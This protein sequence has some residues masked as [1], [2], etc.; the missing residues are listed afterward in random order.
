[1]HGTCCCWQGLLPVALG[2]PSLCC[3]VQE[4]CMLLQC[5]RWPL[6]PS[7]RSLALLHC[8]PYHALL[9]YPPPQVLEEI[10][11]QHIPVMTAWNKVD[12]CP[13]P[14]LVRALAADQPDTHVISGRSGEGLPELLAAIGGK[15]QESMVQVGGAGLEAWLCSRL[16]W[17]PAVSARRQ[18][19]VLPVGHWMPHHAS[20]VPGSH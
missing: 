12:A 20:P 13:D 7:I 3:K 2:A 5:F 8:W 9:H 17:L 19:L 18:A 10:Q 6:M 14:Q 1:M 11:A 4:G 15:L 16:C